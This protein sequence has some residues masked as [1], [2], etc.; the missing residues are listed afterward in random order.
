MR[1]PTG[2][3]ARETSTRS[4]SPHFQLDT[5]VALIADFTSD[6]MSLREQAPDLLKELR[7]SL[8]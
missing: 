7:V 2:L 1:H 3:G 4:F 5:I 6:V 8:H